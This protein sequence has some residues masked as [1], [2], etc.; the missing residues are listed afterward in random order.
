VWGVQEVV[1]SAA[2]LANAAVHVW[3]LPP[4]ICAALA[5]GTTAATAAAAAA[6]VGAT[7]GGGR[8][9]GTRGVGDS[10]AA[11]APTP[12]PSFAA[13]WLVNAVVN[14]NGWVWSAVFHAR[15]TPTTQTLDYAR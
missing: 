10:N 6:A 5:T 9:G 15:D 7:S 8:G 4:L 3:Y 12:S 1:S 11:A 14:I 2:S 13:L